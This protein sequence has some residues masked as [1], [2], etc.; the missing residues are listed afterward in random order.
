MM[1]IVGDITIVKSC[2]TLKYTWAFLHEHSWLPPIQ[3]TIPLILM[4]KFRNGK[5]NS[6]STSSYFQIREV[7]YPNLSLPCTT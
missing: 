6:M 7:I 1:E 3:P 2:R 4:P 5:G